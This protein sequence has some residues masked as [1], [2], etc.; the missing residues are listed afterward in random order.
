MIPAG[1]YRGMDKTRSKTKRQNTVWNIMEVL[2]EITMTQKP[3]YVEAE[4]L[5]EF[6]TEIIR[7][8]DDDFDNMED[9]LCA[10]RNRID[11]Y[12]KETRKKKTKR[13]KK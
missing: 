6:I 11:E 13:G 9:T 10:I 7:E 4:C 8:T 1:Y 3:K 5:F 2:S 12:F